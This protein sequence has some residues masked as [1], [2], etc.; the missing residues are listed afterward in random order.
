VDSQVHTPGGVVTPGV[1]Q[2][3]FAFSYGGTART[4]S[5]PIQSNA[6]VT[7][8]AGERVTLFTL[9]FV[10]V[11]SG[12]QWIDVYIGLAGGDPAGP[13]YYVGSSNRNGG[14]LNFNISD[15]TLQL[16][17]PSTLQVVQGAAEAAYP[18]GGTALG[19]VTKAE[20]VKRSKFGWAN[21][22]ARGR[23][24]VQG[25]RGATSAVLTFALEQF[26]AD[27]LDRLWA[28]N[29][30]SPNG[31][32]GANTLS[33]PQPG[34]SLAPGLMVAS[35]PLLLAADDPTKPSLLVLEPLWSE[36]ERQRWAFQ[37]GVPLKSVVAV[38]VGLNG[39]NLDLRIDKLENLSLT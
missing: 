31:F 35:L 12:V 38:V 7:V 28:E 15:A 19:I 21:S 34:L 13:F 25:W 37:E 14:A 17:T 1:H 23:D 16:G 10:D 5:T 24:Q 8:A 9:G 27:V 39:S 29:T 4:G 11:P 22:E 32:S 6:S 36:E 2:L 26:D 3:G 18:Y 33:L 20:L 30:T